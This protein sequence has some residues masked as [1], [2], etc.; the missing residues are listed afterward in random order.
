MN[1][2]FVLYN[3]INNESLGWAA[4]RAFLILLFTI[5]L[6]KA[7]RATW[8]KISQVNIHQKFIKNVLSTIIWL[9]GIVLALSNFN[10]F[11]NFAGALLAGS[12]IAALTIGLAAQESLGNAFNGLF[13]SLSKPFEVGDRIHLINSNI[14][15]FIEDITIRHTVVRT[16]T[17][18]RIIVPNSLISKEL[19]ENS[20]FFDAK[21]SSFIDIT[22]TYEADIKKACHIMAETIS[23]HPDFIDPR[24][25]EAKA[26]NQPLVAV[27]LRNIGL[28]GAEL[29]ASM[30][31]ENVSN[32]F[33]ACS[34]VRKEI[35]AKFREENIEIAIIKSIP[36][37]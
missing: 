1:N 21:A 24:S 6:I 7:F 12:G 20:N 31:T 16:F 2:S 22:I 36:V 9:A 15:G 25:E 32:N 10:W 23:S 17:N 4:L 14:T 18:S 33:A 29:R 28:H 11:N 8:R 19:I 3:L 35:V 37:Q 5:L 27:F 34:D 26:N 13:I 30:W